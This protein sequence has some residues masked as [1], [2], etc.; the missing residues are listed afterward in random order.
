MPNYYYYYN[1]NEILSTLAGLT[2]DI[3]LGVDLMGWNYDGID[4]DRSSLFVRRINSTDAYE[5]KLKPQQKQSII[6]PENEYPTGMYQ[7][8]LWIYAKNYGQNGCFFIETY[9]NDIYVD[10]RTAPDVEDLV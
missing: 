2:F 10:A 1:R 4:F 9:P 8:S 6:L 3:D 5:F 7:I